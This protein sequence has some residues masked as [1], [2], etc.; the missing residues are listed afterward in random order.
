[1]EDQVKQLLL[2][3]KLPALPEEL[4]NPVGG[5]RSKSFRTQTRSYN[6]MFAMT[7]MGGN[8]DN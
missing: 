8:V 2:L 4:L 3:K 1:M 5:Q 7:S 6:A